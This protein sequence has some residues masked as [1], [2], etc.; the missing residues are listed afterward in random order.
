MFLKAYSRRLLYSTQHLGE[1]ERVVEFT[2][3]L[4]KVMQSL[5]LRAGLYWRVMLSPLHTLLSIA[6][7]VHTFLNPGPFHLYLM[8]GRKEEGE[9]YKDSDFHF[10]AFLKNLSKETSPKRCLA[11]SLI[12][13]LARRCFSGFQSCFVPQVPAIIWN[14][15]T[16]MYQF[17]LNMCTGEKRRL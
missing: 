17:P 5:L 16:E 1:A 11:A 15:V 7:V 13:C 6:P 10:N 9:V 2:C 12:S 8:T 4:V 3:T 14:C